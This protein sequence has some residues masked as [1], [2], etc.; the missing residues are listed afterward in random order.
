[1]ER[2]MILFEGNIAAGKSTL[3][4]TLK[5]SGEFA[6]LPEPVKQWQNYR[7]KNGEVVNLL[8]LFYRD[9]KRWAFT[10]QLAAFTTRVKT[11]TEILARTKSK[12]VVLERSIY[13][14]RNVFAF[15]C[16]QNRS[17]TEF[18]WQI[19]CR[20]W[21]FINEQDWCA[22]PDLI[23][24]IQTPAEVCHQRIVEQRKRDEEK[25]IPLD[26][27][28]SLEELHNNWLLNHPKHPKVVVLDGERRWTA[29]AITEEIHCHL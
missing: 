11:W 21:D 16:Y 18:E 19:Y 15:N 20:M 29:E 27:L 17:M 23:V 22:E 13:C 10:F 8:D 6:F 24:Y 7:L 2:T 28:Q 1:M 3:G 4:E 25:A 14:D 5:E 12:K 9:P 26:Y